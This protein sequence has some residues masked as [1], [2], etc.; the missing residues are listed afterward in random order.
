MA[1]F[2]LVELMNF[3]IVSTAFENEFQGEGRSRFFVS[4]F[5][6]FFL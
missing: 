1:I 4:A 2:W 3:I 6:I 5:L